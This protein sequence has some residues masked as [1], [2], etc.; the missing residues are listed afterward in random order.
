MANKICARQEP[1][2]NHCQH[3]SL[4]TSPWIQLWCHY[5]IL[6]INIMNISI[7]QIH[8]WTNHSNIIVMCNAIIF[9]SL[10]NIWHQVSI[11]ATVQVKLHVLWIASDY[12]LPTCKAQVKCVILITQ[13][14]VAIFMKWVGYETQNWLQY[15]DI[16]IFSPI[17]H[18]SQNQ[19]LPELSLPYDQQL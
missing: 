3:E 4:T 16:N 5:C 19:K 8:I 14:A 2:N 11:V 10:Y 6:P 17:F 18:I 15:L 9:N 1:G 7:I 12:L 13:S